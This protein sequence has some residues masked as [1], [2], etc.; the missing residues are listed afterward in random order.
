M[1]YSTTVTASDGS[2][3]FDLYVAE[4]DGPA[5]G[6]VVVV[7]EIFG[8][9]AGIRRKCD[10][11]AQ[12]GYLAVAPD[13]FWRLQPGVQFDADC[14][15]TQPRAIELVIAFDTDVGVKDIQA[16]ID[17]ARE[18]AGG[19]ARVAVIGYCLGGRMAAFAAARTDG[20]AFVGYY[21]VQIEKML[22]EAGAIAKPLLLHIPE[23]D[24][25]VPAETQAEIHRVFDPHPNV[26]LH[27]YP[28]E[29][30][31]FADAFGDRR[32]EQASRLADDRT[33]A[34]LEASFA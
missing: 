25:H 16:S 20:D 11:F 19:S 30:H 33:A 24:P 15:A 5:H 23:I 6:A 29:H 27:D 10:L 8:V 28:G 22:G 14:K 7:Q 18:L 17:K 2:G 21:G 4:P 34:F 31:G 1:T 26:T 9:N 3:A 32:S 13:M 12:Q